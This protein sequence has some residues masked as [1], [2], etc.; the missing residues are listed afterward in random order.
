MIRE[1]EREGPI[2]VLPFESHRQHRHPERTGTVTVP[3]VMEADLAKGTVASN[4]RQ[5]GR[6]RRQ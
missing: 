3:D 4:V 5:A 6:Q 2:L 1:L